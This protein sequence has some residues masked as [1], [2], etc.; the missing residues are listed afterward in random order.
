M[1]IL[2]LFSRSLMAKL[3]LFG[4]LTMVSTMARA[5][6]SADP[7]APTK[8][9]DPSAIDQIWQ[10]ASSK[11]A[12]QR[13]AILNQVDQVNREGPYGANWQSLRTY[14]LPDWYKDAKFGIF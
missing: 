5:Q 14:E 2:L 1:R 13:S 6:S 7:M 8:S 3:L 9:A 4:A 12:A 10:K 11:Y